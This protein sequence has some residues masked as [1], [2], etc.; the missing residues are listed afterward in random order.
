VLAFTGVDAP[1]D[2][3]LFAALSTRAREILQLLS[4]GLANL[5][6]GR[7]LFISE[8]TV[9]NHVTKIFEKLGV[10]S[11]AHAIVLAKDNGYGS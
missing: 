11:R 6:I 9:R 1:L 5:E 7:E 2:N 4:R 8:K 3:P 10:H